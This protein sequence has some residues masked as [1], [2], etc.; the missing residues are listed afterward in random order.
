MKLLYPI[1]HSAG[2]VGLRL[3]PPNAA[4]NVARILAHYPEEWDRYLHAVRAVVGH[5]RAERDA[6]TYFLGRF[7]GRLKL[8]D[9]RIAEFQDSPD[10]HRV[11]TLFEEL[12]PHFRKE[13]S[14]SSDRV[15]N[16]YMTSGQSRVLATLDTV[17]EAIEAGADPR[18]LF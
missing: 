4:S 18:F 5:D 11:N 12:L 9:P 14:F 16:T 1:V 13:L 3:G 8:T 10:L 15:R 6:V 2:I 17:T 7:G